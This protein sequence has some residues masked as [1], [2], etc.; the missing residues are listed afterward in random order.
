MFFQVSKQEVT[1]LLPFV[2]I[3]EKYRGVLIKFYTALHN[4][5]NREA[6]LKI[7]ELV[8]LKEYSPQRHNNSI[9][10]CLHAC[11]TACSIE[12]AE[13]PRRSTF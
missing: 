10:S 3:V 9:T 1:E 6:K 13:S 8:P 7:P 11:V 2:K 12:S 4:A 5:Q